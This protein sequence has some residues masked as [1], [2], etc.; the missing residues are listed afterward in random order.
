MYDYEL[1]RSLEYIVMTKPKRIII[2]GHMGAGKSLLGKVLAER[3]GWQYF[4]ANLGLERY[5]GRRLHEIIGKQGEE[6]FH[7]C[8]AEILAHYIGKENVVL[9]MDDCVIDTEINRKLLSSEFVVYLQVSAPVQIERLSTGPSS[10]LPIADHKAFLEELHHE[11]DKLFA[12]VATLV[13]NS[14]S[15]EDDVREVLDKLY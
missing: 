14:K 3:L 6:A 1:S 4:D 13:V 10:L 8:E 7:R 12:E 11:R 9:V 5:I 2:V 15:I